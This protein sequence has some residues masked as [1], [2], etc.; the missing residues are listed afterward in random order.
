MGIN[1]KKIKS[2]ARKP[3]LILL[4]ILLFG[5]ALRLLFF[6]GMGTSDDLA[7][8]SYAHNLGKGIDNNS[9][10][11]L[12]TRLGITYPTFVA[13]NLFGIND[14][15]SVLFVLSTSV[16][17]II[18]IYHF[19]SLLFNKKTG[20]MAAFLLSFFPVDVVYA[21][22]LLSDLPSAFFMSLGVYFFLYCEK[23]SRFK[24]GY[25][26]SGIFIGIAYLIRESSVLIILF[27]GIYA[28]AKRKIKLEYFFVA[29][30][31]ATIFL[32]EMFAFYNLTGDPL[33]R[34]NA[35]Q[36]YLLKANEKYNYF[37]RLSFPMGLLHYPYLFL[38]SNT[39]S[40][41]YTFIAIAVFYSVIYKKKRAYTMLI[42]F[43]PL[44]IYLSFGSSSL[45]VYAPFK[46]TERYLAIITIPALLLLSYLLL[47]K[48][49]IVQKT[50]MPS[51]LIILFLTSI[52]AVY[53]RNDRGLLND[54]KKANLYL[55]KLEKT[56]Y[57]DS[58]S[59][60]ALNYI[61]NYSS[62]IS[63]K[64]YPQNLAFIKD[65]YIVINKNMIK[66]LKQ[67]NKADKLPPDINSPPKSWTLVKEIGKGEN[68]KILIYYAP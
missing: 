55:E 12:S 34:I 3:K 36:S 47:E 1:Y 52:G 9:V 44:L 13:Y 51:A 66:N 57:T 39:L 8:T 42:W 59:I 61:S 63:L 64:E 68:D 19:G 43:I 11:T 2:I 4:L 17:G 48:N 7:Y 38:S 29:F 14:L 33:F 54:L 15:S 21:T 30:G 26:L 40:F 18:L 6:S 22:K 37:G 46:A 53:L 62:R 41:F 16:A 24:L 67:A 50:I 45:T 23:K 49:E 32:F 60:H 5:L 25:F 56:V 28:I 58:R 27:F 10:L 65:S 31:F 20:L 35:S